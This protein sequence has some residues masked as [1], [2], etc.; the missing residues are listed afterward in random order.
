M[1]SLKNQR[2][3]HQ[4]QEPRQRSVDK[5]QSPI[6]TKDAPAEFAPG[7]FMATGYPTMTKAGHR[8]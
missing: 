5:H 4:D 2:G 6:A 3:R 8:H 7:T 1:L